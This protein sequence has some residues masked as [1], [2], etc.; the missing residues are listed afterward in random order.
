MIGGLDKDPNIINLL[1]ETMSYGID[2]EVWCIQKASQI[3]TWEKLFGV[4]RDDLWIA[5]I[6][7]LFLISLLLYLI[8]RSTNIHRNIY[9]ALLHGLEISISNPTNLLWSS[10]QFHYRIL[11]FTMILYGMLIN[12]L[13]SCFL[14]TTLTHQRF[15]RQISS[16][17]ETIEKNFTY[18]GDQV[19]YTHLTLRDDAVCSIFFSLFFS[20]SIK[21]L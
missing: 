9:W 17:T 21:N 7:T 1:W 8:F 18:A 15:Q 14:V 12:M 16:V 6:I 20:L 2:D 19:V 4:F 11:V 5:T 3:P 10:I 13:F